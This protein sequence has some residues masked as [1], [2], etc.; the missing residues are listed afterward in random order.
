MYE[1]SLT[2]ENLVQVLSTHV[3]ST[4]QIRLEKIILK[5]CAIK[6]YFKSP[7]Y[8]NNEKRQK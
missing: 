5:K 3:R 6:Q 1:L 8:I 4:L 7:I 2:N